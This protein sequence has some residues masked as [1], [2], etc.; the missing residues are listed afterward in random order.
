A[1]ALQRRARAENRRL[2][3]VTRAGEVLTAEGLLTGGA[4]GDT[5]ASVLQRKNHTAALEEEITRQRETVGAMTS[6]RNA[7]LSQVESSQAAVAE[8]RDGKQEAAVRLSTLKGQLQMIE[9]HLAEATRKRESLD[10]EKQTAEARRVEAAAQIE[11]FEAGVREAMQ[12]FESV[13]LR[14]NDGQAMLETLRARENEIASELNELKIKVATERSRHSSL[15]NQ[16]QPMEARIQELRD[17]I[18]Q[19]RSDI[20]SYEERAA[21]LEA[22]KS[23]IEASVARLR[24]SIADA[25]RHVATVQEERACLV[26]AAEEMAEKL[27][28]LRRE[29]SH[30]VEQRGAIEV[31]ATQLELKADA[32]GDHIQKRY[33][34]GLAEFTP[35]G[36]AL[37]LCMREIGKRIRKFETQVEPG[38]EAPEPVA[39]EAEEEAPV[40]EQAGSVDWLRIESIVKELDTRLS[41]MGPVNID[42]IAEFDEL[43]QRHNFLEQQIADTIAAKDELLSVINKINITTKA[44]FADTF[45]K[46]RVNFQEMFRE[47][48]GGGQ[49]N[50]ILVDEADPLESGIDIIARPPGKQLQTISLLSG[51]ERTMTAVALLFSIYM[52]KPSPFC[53][54][55]EMDAP[56]DESNISRFIKILDRFVSQSQF[57]VISHNKRTIA[58]ADALYGV[59]MEEHGVSKLVGVKFRSRED[60]HEGRDILGSDNPTPVP[61]IAESFGKRGNLHTEDVESANGAA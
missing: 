23:E 2:S 55:D 24:E 9:T 59:T 17:L 21:A 13:L 37:A 11:Q 7:I 26:A 46:V 60:A 56:L 54:L 58:R 44:L 18:E 28:V 33:Q 50:L 49:S 12:S 41:A 51:G 3:V 35:D 36:Y 61:S 48:F 45:E 32:I 47:L 4:G 29:Q 38:A 42:A 39:A 53:V 19:R 22:E 20:Q 14:R 15:H 34:L 5:G 25:E 10:W 31:R 16:R 6:R 27:R 43:E 52:V 8:A 1:I 57:V 40:D 30:C